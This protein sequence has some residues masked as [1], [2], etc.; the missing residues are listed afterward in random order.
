MGKRLSCYGKLG[1]R[2]RFEPEQG[3]LWKCTWKSGIERMVEKPLPE[4][5]LKFPG[6]I[7]SRDL[8]VKSLFLFCL[9]LILS[10]QITETSLTEAQTRLL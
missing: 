7:Q 8:L 2:E 4:K 6:D 10:F 3:V 5:M 9:G 1:L